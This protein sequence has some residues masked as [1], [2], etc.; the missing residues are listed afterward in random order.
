MPRRNFGGHIKITPSVHQ[1]VGWSVRY[2]SCVSH[3]SKSKKG[4]LIKLHRK[5]KQNKKVCQAQN[6]G[7]HDQGQG[8]NCRSSVCHLQIMCQP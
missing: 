8:H 1:S 2:K 7:S 6:L 3:N 4:N 5:V